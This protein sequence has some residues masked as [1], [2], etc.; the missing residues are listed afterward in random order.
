[1]LVICPLAK[2]HTPSANVSLLTAVKSKT[3]D[4]LIRS[5]NIGYFLNSVTTDHFRITNP[6]VARVASAAESF[7]LHK[8]ARPASC[9]TDCRELKNKILGLSPVT[10]RPYEVS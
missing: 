8:F 3:I 7:P 4:V 2:F 6:I 1:V 9:V 10:Q 5:T